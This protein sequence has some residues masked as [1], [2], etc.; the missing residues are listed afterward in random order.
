MQSPIPASHRTSKTSDTTQSNWAH[1]LMKSSSLQE[2]SAKHYCIIKHSLAK[3]V[4][5]E[6]RNILL[7]AR[8]TAW[9]LMPIVLSMV[10][11]ANTE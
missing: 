2:L 6:Q 5:N 8:Q 11:Q 9:E 10:T 1:F 3:H 4:K 7:S